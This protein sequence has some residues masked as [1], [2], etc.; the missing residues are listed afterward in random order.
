MQ[1]AVATTTASLIGLVLEEPNS[2]LRHLTDSKKNK[3]KKAKELPSS[4]E[5]IRYLVHEQTGDRVDIDDPI[6]VKLES[7][8]TEYF[9]ALQQC[10]QSLNHGYNLDR[11]PEEL[12]E[13][14]CRSLDKRLFPYVSDLP[15]DRDEK[16]AISLFLV[17]LFILT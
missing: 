1:S 2:A 3:A 5:R 17:S 12:I 14:G 16:L 6:F 15:V 11:D 8:H 9:D 4:S 13:Q 10:M 7:L